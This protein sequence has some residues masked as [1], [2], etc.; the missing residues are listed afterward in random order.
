M[1]NYF[2]SKMI[3]SKTFKKKKIIITDKEIKEFHKLKKL[4]KE[5]LILKTINEKILLTQ[6]NFR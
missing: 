2:S 6:K 4:L 1:K 3:Y 5:K